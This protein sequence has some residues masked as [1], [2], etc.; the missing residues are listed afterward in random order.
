MTYVIFLKIIIFINLSRL[1]LFCQKKNYVFC[2]TDKAGMV[3]E[4]A[5]ANKIL[6]EN[7]FKQGH[8]QNGVYSALY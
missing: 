2:L 4:A 1:F 5:M 7:S 6:A 3:L 8:L